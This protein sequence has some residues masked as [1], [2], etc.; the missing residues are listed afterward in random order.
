MVVSEHLRL[1]VAAKEVDM[2]QNYLDSQGHVFTYMKDQVQSPWHGN[3]S[4]KTFSYLSKL[5]SSVYAV[6]LLHFLCCYCL[7]S[8]LIIP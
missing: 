8:K 3:I 2:T 5:G 7:Y 4:E 6:I 1:L